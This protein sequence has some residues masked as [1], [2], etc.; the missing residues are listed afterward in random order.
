MT[1]SR[2]IDRRNFQA[3]F[4][5]ALRNSDEN[6]LWLN[7]MTQFGNDAIPVVSNTSPNAQ[8]TWT[9]TDIVQGITATRGTGAAAYLSEDIGDF[10]RIEPEVRMSF[11]DRGP[12]SM[13]AALRYVLARET[14]DDN[15]E[16]KQNNVGAAVR[17]MFDRTWGGDI[18]MSKNVDFT[19]T[20]PT[21]VE[22]EIDTGFS[23][24][25]Y[26]KY[27]PAMNFILSLQVGNQTR[28][29]LRTPGSATENADVLK[30][31]SWSLGADILF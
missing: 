10:V 26:L 9:Y 21:G 31:W 14:Y 12:H 8:R 7:V 4:A 20:D 17:Y 30:G 5:Y 23:Y 22:H 19:L 18:L 13:E 24:T 27:Q 11:I 25:G 16:A 29:V 3:Q 28:G 6:E 2:G 1:T 15:S